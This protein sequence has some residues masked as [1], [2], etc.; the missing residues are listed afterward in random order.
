MR[1]T[2]SSH[3]ICTRCPTWLDSVPGVIDSK[4]AQECQAAIVFYSAA[5]VN[6]ARFRIT[7]IGSVRK[8][9]QQ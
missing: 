4:N 5:V 2:P 8:K 6:A 9:E 3:A 1:G 7:G